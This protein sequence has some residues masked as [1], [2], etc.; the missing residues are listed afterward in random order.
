MGRPNHA[1]S[2]ISMSRSRILSIDP[3]LA[4]ARNTALWGGILLTFAFWN[5]SSIFSSS[6]AAIPKTAQP[7]APGRSSLALDC[8]NMRPQS[9]THTRL[10]SM[11]KLY[12][13]LKFVE[14]GT[15]TAFHRPPEIPTRCV[16]GLPSSPGW[17]NSGSRFAV[18]QFGTVSSSSKQ[19]QSRFHIEERRGEETHSNSRTALT[20]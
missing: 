12:K 1:L 8:A 13:V 15:A 4:Y 20:V 10:V 6:S 3:E 2:H 19:S 14:I 11:E 16:S 18:L 17:S 5:C 9:R 7:Q